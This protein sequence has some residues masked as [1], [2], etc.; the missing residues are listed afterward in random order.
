MNPA[1]S[2]RLSATAVRRTLSRAHLSLG[3]LPIADRIGRLGAV[4]IA[5]ADAPFPFRVRWLP[6]HPCRSGGAG[7]AHA[8][9]RIEAVPGAGAGDRGGVSG[10][11]LTDNRAARET[12]RPPF[13]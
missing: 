6:G 8:G 7:A 2:V 5:H 4:V 12:G 11:L 9:G 1:R 13:S 10:R 3:R